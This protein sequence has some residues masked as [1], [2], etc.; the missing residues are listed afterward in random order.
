MNHQRYQNFIFN[1]SFLLKIKFTTKNYIPIKANMNIKRSSNKAIYANYSN[2]LIIT[3]II[4][5]INLNDLN[6][7]VTLSTLKVLSTL[8]AEITFIPLEKNHSIT[9]NITTIP[10]KILKVSEQ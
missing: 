1:F 3:L 6:N 7:L 4:T 10:S 8:K 9:D 5:F 2:E